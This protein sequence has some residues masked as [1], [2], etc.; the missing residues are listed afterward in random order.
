MRC[1]QTLHHRHHLHHLLA[2][3]AWRRLIAA[4]LSVALLSTAWAPADAAP[5]A[6]LT[7]TASTAYAYG[8]A[9]L[10]QL[11]YA[12]PAGAGPTPLIVFVHGGG[13]QRGDK[14]SATGP[15]QVAHWTGNGYAFASINY[16][17]VP[18]AIVE[19]QAADVAAAIAWL[20]SNAGRLNIDTTRVV[21]M[22]HSAGAHLV[23]LVGTDPQYLAA[24]GMTLS[25]LRGV[26]ALDG[27]AY[28]VARQI[29]DSGRLMRST[30]LAAFGND[31][32]RQRQLSPTLQ[33]AAPNAPAFL[34]AHV[35][36]ADGKAQAKALGAALRE[37]GTP[38]QVT[39]VDGKGLRGHME[40][41]RLLGNA[42][43]PGTAVI[44]DWLRTLLQPGAPR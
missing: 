34:L 11:D 26:I 36:R 30:Y 43:Y 10:Q 15:Q 12:H 4:T 28:D 37:A 13:W 35:D 16:R 5:A 41:N 44:D 29:A 42:S 22:G 24:A 20:R 23:A 2:A 6:P 40:I 7:P 31:A 3:A 33:A 18:N 9:P 17:L 21:L 1:L 39:S 38:V 32:A 14:A 25:D 8:A 19:Q 27:A